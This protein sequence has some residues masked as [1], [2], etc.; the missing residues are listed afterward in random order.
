MQGNHRTDIS[1]QKIKQR[2]VAVLHSAWM[3]T[4]YVPGGSLE[5]NEESRQES[6]DTKWRLNSDNS[7]SSKLPGAIPVTDLFVLDEINN[8][9]VMSCTKQILLQQL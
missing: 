3:L 5:A 1:F 8:Y 2:N 4:V 7:L 9:P 6:Q